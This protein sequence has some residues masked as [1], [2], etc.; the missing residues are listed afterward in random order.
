MTNRIHARPALLLAAGLVLLAGCTGLDK[1]EGAAQAAPVPPPP[2]TGT[3][4][5]QNTAQKAGKK[6]ED[7]PDRVLAPLDNAVNVINRDIN[8]DLDKEFPENKNAPP[9][10]DPDE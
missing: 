10:Q 3:N 2:G 8:R 1:R 5:T 4:A 6:P 7:L 9:P